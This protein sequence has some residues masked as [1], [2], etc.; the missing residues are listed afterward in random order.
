MP[1]A[2]GRAGGPALLS[3]RVALLPYLG[4]NEL[5][6]QFHLNEPWD[7]P[8]NKQLLK[9]MP[10]VYAPPGVRTQEP[11]ATYYQVFVGPH[12]AFEKHQALPISSFTDGT[13]NT[14][15]IVEAAHA[16]P[17]TKPEDL[18]YAADEPLPELG[19]L[20]PG[21]F[22][23]AS[24]DGAVHAVP[25][26][27]DPRVLRALITRDMGEV[28]GWSQLPSASTDGGSLRQQNEELRRAVEA[29]RGEI[30]ALRRQRDLLQRDA[31]DPAVEQLR[32]ENAQ[33]RDLLKQTQAE[34]ARLEEEIRRIR[35][36]GRQY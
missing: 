30:E 31:D 29:S 34:K 11:Y 15:L 36:G 2:P 23:A 25:K 26:A 4:E 35:S 3:W 21:I 19:G 16:V 8:H 27:T 22:N 18:H 14:I 12:A 6:R 1:D 9:R 7:S 10:H 24:A 33:L 5:Y 13:S 20:F 28:E 32:K 17:W